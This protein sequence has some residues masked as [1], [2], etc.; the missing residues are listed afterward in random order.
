MIALTG[1]KG[2]IGSYIADSLPFPQKRLVRHSLSSLNKKCTLV[3]G[4][5]SNQRDIET[6][7]EDTQ[8]LI[9]LAWM[10]N[11]WNSNRDV[12]NDIT[13]NLVFSVKLFETFAKKNPKGHIIFASTGGNMYKGKIPFTEL[14][15]PRPWSSYSINK[16]AAEQYLHSFCEHYGISATVMRISNPYGILLP[17][18][19]T[20]GLIG[21]IFAKLLN[22]ESLNII[23][24]L[25]SIRDYIHLDDLKK[26]FHTIIQNPPSSGEF[27]LFNISS[28]VGYTLEE[29]LHLIEKVTHKKI[30]KNFVNANV[31]PTASVLSPKF[32]KEKL[33]WEPQINLEEGL[34]MMWKNLRQE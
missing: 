23:D 2:F 28:G 10:N 13:Q 24:S 4:D 8:T 7:V 21:V 3:L 1:S 5:L 25:K 15:P 31:S 33:S 19:R 30:L 29:V 17:S 34:G 9:H 18:S 27:R 26:A 20:N 6:L 16:L 11:P 14:D 32:I 22:N 12:S